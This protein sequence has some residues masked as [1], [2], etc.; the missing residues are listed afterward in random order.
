MILSADDLSTESGTMHKSNVVMASGFSL[1]RLATPL[2]PHSMASAVRRIAPNRCQPL[3]AMLFNYNNLTSHNSKVL[4]R[5]R[6]RNCPNILRIPISTTLIKGVAQVNRSGS[7][8]LV[9][10]PAP[11]ALARIVDTPDTSAVGN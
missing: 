1:A 11:P 3:R 6:S 8:A 2:L 10:Y 5:I 4:I 7:S 9:G